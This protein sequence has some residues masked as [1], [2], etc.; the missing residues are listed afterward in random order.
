[1]VL[2]LSWW[3]CAGRAFVRG[4]RMATVL[5]DGCDYSAC[6]RLRDEW[7]LIVVIWRN[8]KSASERERE[9]ISEHGQHVT[10]HVLR[11]KRA[12]REFLDSM[13]ADHVEADDG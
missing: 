10:L 9:I 6:L 13:G 5:P 2:D 11:S 4:F 8:R 3:L 1:M 7:R 12:V